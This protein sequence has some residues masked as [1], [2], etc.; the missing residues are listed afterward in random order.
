VTS[1]LTLSNR[2]TELEHRKIVR[3]VSVWRPHRATL[4]ASRATRAFTSPTRTAF[5]A[6][7]PP[8]DVRPTLENAAESTI[9]CASG[10][11]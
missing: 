10:D 11:D 3:F 7:P 1:V 9:P 5:D 2:R 4:G 6:A 8:T